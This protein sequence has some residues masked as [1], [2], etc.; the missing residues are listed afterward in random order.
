MNELV[1]KVSV[2][3]GTVLDDNWVS[4]G[5]DVWVK[6]PGHW[7][8]AQRERGVGGTER[9]VDCKQWNE[10]KGKQDIA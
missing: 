9:E 4:E 6:L 1:S 3:N 5:V 8:K 10:E 2:R 7:V